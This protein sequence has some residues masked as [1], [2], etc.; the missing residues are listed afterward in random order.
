MKITDFMRNIKKDEQKQLVIIFKKTVLD[1]YS[2]NRFSAQSNLGDFIVDYLLGEQIAEIYQL[3]D[4]EKFTLLNVLRSIKN[5]LKSKF[6]VVRYC[7]NEYDKSYYKLRAIFEK[8]LFEA[9]VRKQ[10]EETIYLNKV[11]RIHLT[12]LLKYK[13]KVKFNFAEND[14]KKYLNALSLDEKKK[15]KYLKVK[16]SYNE[17]DY[18]N[19]QMLDLMYLYNEET[20]TNKDD[21]MKIINDERYKYILLPFE[22]SSIHTV[23]QVNV[24]KQT[25]EMLRS[26]EREDEFYLIAPKYK[27][28]H[29]YLYWS[30]FIMQLNKSNL[31]TG[32]ILNEY[33]LIYEIEK[34]PFTNLIIINYDEISENNYEL[35]HFKEN[36]EQK[37]RF[38]KQIAKEN[39]IKV[40][41]KSNNLKNETIIE[42]LI[43]MGFKTFIYNENHY[44]HVKKSVLNYMSRR[45]KYKLKFKK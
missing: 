25:K 7:L 42:K 19:D 22:I 41:V 20:F 44:S 26:V 13:K 8:I 45:G 28:Y 1:Y 35:R 34:A 27:N 24:I 6:I 9:Y 12:I 29:H 23:S 11:K 5:K 17:L 4:D 3:I 38:I 36:I 14:V 43:I 37:M 15:S 39:D 30:V 2:N 33:E 40:V 32:I 31:K 18:L 21:I 10:Y 16:E